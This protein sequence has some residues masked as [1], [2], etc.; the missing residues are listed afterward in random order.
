[1]WRSTSANIC[2]SSARLGEEAEGERMRK[3]RKERRGSRD[4]RLEETWA[5]RKG[6]ARG[7]MKERKKRER[8]AREQRTREA[9]SEREK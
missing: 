7:R 9:K 3:G 5:G 8:E 1:M 6:I 4:R 2:F